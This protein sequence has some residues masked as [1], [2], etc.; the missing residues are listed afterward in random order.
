MIDPEA[1][2]FAFLAVGV[3]IGAIAVATAF[4]LMR[5]ADMRAA[6]DEWAE[7]VDAK[8]DAWLV[9]NVNAMAPRS[10]T[11]KPALGQPRPEKRL[12]FLPEED[13]FRDN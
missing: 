10:A 5:I 13:Q 12:P 6:V 2:R 8:V 3:A 4:A 11:A 7:D 9:A 1:V